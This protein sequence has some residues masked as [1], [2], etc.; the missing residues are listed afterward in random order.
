MALITSLHD[1]G[2]EAYIRGPRHIV[3]A[4]TSNLLHLFWC[5]HKRMQSDVTA[6]RAS[7]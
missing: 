6:R 3:T 1:P 7:T 5:Y 4:V 2:R